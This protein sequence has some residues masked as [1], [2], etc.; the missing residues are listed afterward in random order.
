MFQP[1]SAQASHKLWQASPK[2]RA[3]FSS[4]VD[5]VTH[6]SSISALHPLGSSNEI[7]PEPRMSVQVGLGCEENSMAKFCQQAVE[8]AGC[9]MCKLAGGGR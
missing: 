5:P 6:L 8:T 1:K 4:K 3:S 2:S 7:M 9:T